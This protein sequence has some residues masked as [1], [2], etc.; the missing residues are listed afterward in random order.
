MVA[1]LVVLT[2]LIVLT[3]DYI[4]TERA[5]GGLSRALAVGPAV[6]TPPAAPQPDRAMLDGRLDALPEG[7]SVSQGH[8]WVRP[9]SH[10]VVRLGI[11]RVIV[12]LLGRLE[13]LYGLPEGVEVRR[14]GPLVMLRNGNRALKIRCPADGVISR[15]NREV[16]TDPGRVAEDPFH[17]G[18][19]YE[20]TLKDASREVPGVVA[21]MDAAWWMHREAKRL[22]EIA[23][24]YTGLR[25]PHPTMADG[26]IPILPL[27]RQIESSLQDDEWEDLVACYFK[28]SSTRE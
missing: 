8:V 20:V 14:G 5:R 25:S 12:A 27:G 15:V 4:V 1:L 24:A 7:T 23:S 10:G 17:G 28:E 22:Y 6:V 21:G 11:D 26:G 19:L 9:Q 18:W 16:S 3:L 2:I 13:F